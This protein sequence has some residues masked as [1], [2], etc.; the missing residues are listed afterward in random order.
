MRQRAKN[1]VRSVLR[2]LGFEIRRIRVSRETV[3]AHAGEDA[4]YYLEYSSTFPV[5]APWTRPDF[6]AMYSEVAG[7]VSGS[8]ERA[9]ALL[10]F[11]RYAK[12]LPGD[13]AECGVYQGGSALWL[14]KVLQDTNKTL[15]LFDSFQGLSKPDPRHDPHYKEGQYSAPAEAVKHRLSNFNQITDFRVGWIPDTFGGLE[16]KQYAFANIDVDLYQPTLDCCVYF[17]PRLVPGGVMVFDEYC[18]ASAHGEKVAVDQYFAD[19]LDRPIALITGQAFVLK[20]P[21]Q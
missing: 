13:F 17:Y 20:T 1:I 3:A 9:Y 11:A 18:F 10:S 15:Y 8:P 7:L 14:C 4:A 5:F 12:F 16:D 19:K 2:L 21:T 6:Q